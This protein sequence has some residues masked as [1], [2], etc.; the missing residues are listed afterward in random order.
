MMGYKGRVGVHEVMTMT[1]VLRE[2]VLKK[3]SATLLRTC[4]IQE[5]MV[6]LI[7]DGFMKV[8]N[9]LTTVEEILKIRYE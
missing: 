4:A 3:N 2:L 1:P 5:G 7:E 8:Q 6:P 9:G